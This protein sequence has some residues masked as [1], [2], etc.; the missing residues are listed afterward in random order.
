MTAKRGGRDFN[1]GLVWSKY[2]LFQNTNLG[3]YS[4]YINVYIIVNQS[5]EGFNIHCLFIRRQICNKEKLW[6]ANTIV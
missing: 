4:T 2:I 6:I 1:L 5:M 3:F